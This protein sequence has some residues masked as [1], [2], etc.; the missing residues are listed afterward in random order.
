MKLKQLSVLVHQQIVSTT[1]RVS[2]R[3]GKGEFPVV[4]ASFNLVF[5][6][7]N[8]SFHCWPVGERPKNENFRPQKLLE[9]HELNTPRCLGGTFSYARY[10]CLNKLDS[11]NHE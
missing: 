2:S 10:F 8:C 6:V 3:H 1:F 9:L 7:Q 4:V 11:L 5:A